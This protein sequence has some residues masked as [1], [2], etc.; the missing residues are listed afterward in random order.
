MACVQTLQT[1]ITLRCSEKGTFH[2]PMSHPN[3]RQRKTPYESDP[4]G[5]LVFCCFLERKTI[6]FSAEILSSLWMSSMFTRTNMG[7]YNRL[8][9]I[10]ISSNP[11]IM[12]N[13]C[14]Y[15]Y[16]YIYIHIYTYTFRGF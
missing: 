16:I 15:I 3:N 6:D 10:E 7:K 4:F 8:T 14:I 12:M 13:I 5:P 9:S 2:E 11:Q 1:A